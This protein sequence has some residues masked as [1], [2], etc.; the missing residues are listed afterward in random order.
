M[1]AVRPPGGVNAQAFPAHA[2]GGGGLVLQSY[3]RVMKDALGGYVTLRRGFAKLIGNPEFMRLAVKYGLPRTTMLKYL[4]KIM[5]NMA[6]T[7]GGD[8]A[9]R[10]I[11]VL[12]KMAPAS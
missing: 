4:L 1:A 10:L 5:A 6:E 12:S 9:D 7:H 8:V 3:P 11:N 2:T